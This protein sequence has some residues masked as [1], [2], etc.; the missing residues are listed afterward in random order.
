MAL[1]EI[2]KKQV[3]DL[4]DE[5]INLRRDFHMHP[6][7]SFEEWRTSKVVLDYLNSLGLEVKGGIAKT[8][9]VGILRGKK[10]GGTILLRADMDALP[11]QEENEVSYKSINEGKMHACGHDGHTAMLLVAA[12]VLCQHKDQINGNIKFVFQ[13]A[14]ETAGARFMIEEG[15][16]E[17]PHVDA[18]LGIHLETSLKS[19]EIGITAGPIMAG[20]DYFKLTIE[21]KG[22]HTGYPHSS[23]DPIMAAANV[24]TTAQII[25]TR[26]IDV[27]KRTILI[28]FGRIEGGVAPNTIPGKVELGGTVRYLHRSAEE[29]EKKFERIIA[30]VCE[31]HGTKYELK[32]M[33]SNRSLSNDSKMVKLVRSVAQ[34]LVPRNHIVSDIR[35]M[36]G[37]DFSEF[38]SKVP[39]AFYFIGTGNEEK[40]TNYPHHHPRFNIDEDTLSMGVEMHVGTALAYLSSNLSPYQ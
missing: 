27:L 19:G 11:I 16:L 3:A 29:E 32:F 5:L 14:E 38:A 24:I 17:D 20:A 34:K 13:P 40:E 1:E 6:E 18:A 7:L 15:V 36:G 25:Q 2:I 9:V 37:E 12:K 28:A 22:G 23:I 8:G 21:G 4:N 31:A 33:P 10:A 35:S 39:S 26:E 30:G